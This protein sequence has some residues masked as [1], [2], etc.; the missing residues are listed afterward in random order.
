MTDGQRVSRNVVVGLGAWQA[1][2]ETNKAAFFQGWVQ[3]PE[4][5]AR[6]PVGMSPGDFA[7]A[8]NANA[9]LVLTQAEFD[10]LVNMLTNNNTTFGRAAA[11]RL[12]AEN[13]EFSRR[14]F[15]CAFVLMQYFGY[16]RRNPDDAPEPNRDFSG[17]RFWLSKLEE[18]QGNYVSAEMVKAF[19]SSD[20]Y[21]KRFGQ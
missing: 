17:Y 14:E 9:G 4:F 12:V 20:E 21:R 5:L 6:Y 3:R 11:V 1:Q 2:L 19:I 13:G 18:F 8:L 16:L 15:N 7:A 10:S